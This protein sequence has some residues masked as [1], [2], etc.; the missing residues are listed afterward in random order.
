MAWPGTNPLGCQAWQ[1]QHSIPL[2]VFEYYSLRSQGLIQARS[3][4]EWEDETAGYSFFGC[5]LQQD[6]LALADAGK[7]KV[8]VR[9]GRVDWSMGIRGKK[10]RGECKC[11]ECAEM[12]PLSC[13]SKG[14]TGGRGGKG[15]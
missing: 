1:I 12:A 8:K 6:A 2:S 10:V 4:E 13:K 3:D 14:G 9:F 11:A 15:G 5:C 7:L